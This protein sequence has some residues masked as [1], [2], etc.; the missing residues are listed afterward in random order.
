MYGH[1]GLATMIYSIQLT[2]KSVLDFFLASYNLG[3][4]S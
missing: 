3:D 4:L 2:S 1:F